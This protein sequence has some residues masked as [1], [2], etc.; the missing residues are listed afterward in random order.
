MV[1]PAIQAFLVFI[2]S[3]N[4][5]EA[6]L[7]ELEYA[8]STFVRLSRKHSCTGQQTNA[9]YGR[10]G[11]GTPLPVDSLR[12]LKAVVKELENFGVED[13]S[14]YKRGAV[15]C[16]IPATKGFEEAPTIAYLSHIDQACAFKPQQIGRY[17]LP[18]APKMALDLLQVLYNLYMYAGTFGF[19]YRGLNFT[20]VKPRV[21]HNW[22]GEPINFP[23]APDL[24]M[25]LDVPR[26]KTAVNKTLIVGSGRTPLGADGIAGAVS[27]LLLAQRLLNSKQ[28]HGPVRLVFLPTGELLTG[29]KFMPAKDIKAD[30]AYMLDAEIP[31]DIKYESPYQ[32]EVLISIKSYLLHHGLGGGTSLDYPA[33]YNLTLCH[34]PH[35]AARLGAIIADSPFSA[36][37]SDGRTPYI[38]ITDVKYKALNDTREAIM[39]VTVS[40]FDE[41]GL[42]ASHAI[43]KS[44]V[45]AIAERHGKCATF[46]V[47]PPRRYMTNSWDFMD[48]DAALIRLARASMRKAGLI[49]VSTPMRGLTEAWTYSKNKLPTIL[50]FSGWHGAHGPFEWTTG[51]VTSVPFPSSVDINTF[52]SF[53]AG[54]EMIQVTDVITELTQQWFVQSVRKECLT[55]HAYEEDF[56]E[57]RKHEEYERYMQS[58]LTN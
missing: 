51:I 27:M 28:P 1:P 52:S 4:L 20:K 11:A 53:P 49:P 18:F 7:N 43:I 35:V 58:F 2:L 3:L 23:D 8:T 40:A 37:N 42:A 39:H 14:N 6:T 10:N 13:T 17:C 5:I 34:L 33:V 21:F 31:G 22:S 48:K 47:N 12:I 50:L 30:A 32:E 44:A 16:T 57:K 56:A 24:L 25:S 29:V 36:E 46:N 45:Q 9:G 55:G 19:G 15:M 38:I 26:L 54:E 41:K